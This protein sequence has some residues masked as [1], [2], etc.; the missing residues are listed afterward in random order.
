MTDSRD[1]HARARRAV[2]AKPEGGLFHEKKWRVSPDGFAITPEFADELDKLGYRLVRFQQACNQL[3]YQSVRGRQPA[4]IA[5][6]LD[7]GKPAELIEF[8]RNHAFR[9][10]LPAVIRPDVILTDDGYVLAELD[11][12]P[13]GIG[14]TAW[15]AEVYSG[16]GEDVLG[17]RDGMLSG[18]ATALPGGQI[19]VSEEASTYRPEME[20]LVGRLNSEH[21]ETGK[22]RVT[23]AAG[24]DGF[25][26]NVY[27][28][29][30]L[31][32]LDQVPCAGALMDHALA[33][34]VRVTAP[35]KPWMEEKLWF[36]LFWLK[37]LEGFWRN[38]LSE[39]V[40]TA[41]QK[42]IPYSWLVDPTPLP[43][44]AVLPRMDAHSWD[45]VA[46]FSQKQRDFILKISGFSDQAWGSRGV[47][48]AADV[49]QPEW[50]AELQAALAAYPSQPHILQEFHK[51]RLVEQAWLDEENGELKSMKGRVRLCPYYFPDGDRVR[52]SGALATI[53]PADKKLLHGMQDAVMVP[54]VVRPEV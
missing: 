26:A 48:A 34:S 20:W 21:S 19:I 23:D 6:L 5:G 27:R 30:E 38:E 42:V 9:N 35:I 10:D 47:V 46:A 39:R 28:F 13:G 17:G 32:D 49:P 36:A 45:D 54:A 41:L 52:C 51:G 4:W 33:G 7:R 53:C 40:F 18:F 1:P 11:S 31:F 14:L 22:W 24:R 12:V 43:V 25:D 15:L 16:L 50:K 2:D 3:Y 37:P 44:H 29:F 8:A